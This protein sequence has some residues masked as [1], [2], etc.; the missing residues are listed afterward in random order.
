MTEGRALLQL[1]VSRNLAARML[2]WAHRG[3]LGRGGSLDT[4]PRLLRLAA[5]GLALEWYRR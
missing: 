2:A 5:V 1:G 4:K 3:K